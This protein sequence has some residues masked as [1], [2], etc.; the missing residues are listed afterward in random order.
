VLFREIRNPTALINFVACKSACRTILGA[1][2]L[3]K[4]TGFKLE[5]TATWALLHNVCQTQLNMLCLLNDVFVICR[6]RMPAQK[7]PSSE[8]CVSEDST[9][10]QERLALPGPSVINRLLQPAGISAI[11][12]NLESF[13]L[14]TKHVSRDY[15]PAK[16]RLAGGARR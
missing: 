12:S 15:P 8:A 9:V 3:L 14:L 16:S 13:P 1:R 7:T 2:K 5:A 4:R 10:W 6:N 11:F